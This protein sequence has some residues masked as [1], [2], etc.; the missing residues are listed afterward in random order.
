MKE[1]TLKGNAIE[2]K[3]GQSVFQGYSQEKWKKKCSVDTLFLK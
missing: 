2:S 3:T 1:I